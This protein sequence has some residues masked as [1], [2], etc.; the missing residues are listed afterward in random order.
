[1]FFFDTND[2]KT[3]EIYLSLVGTYEADIKKSWV[4]SYRFDICLLD[5]TKIGV[6]NLRIDNTE[7]TKYCGNIGYIIDEK[8][9]GN[10][11]SLKASKLVL[12]LAKKHGLKYVLVNC[13]PENI[14]SNKICKLLNADFVE[15]VDI[16]ETHEMYEQGT[17]RM[18]IYKIDLK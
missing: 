14:A 15:T 3:S 13:E 7:L 18:N 5:G 17:R 8:Y 9:R 1:M 11:Y 12:G 4:P 10:K 2:L 16:P 6:C